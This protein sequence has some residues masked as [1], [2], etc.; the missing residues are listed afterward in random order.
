MSH[1]A[2]VLAAALHLVLDAQ[3][4]LA[5]LGGHLRLSL[6]AG[7]AVPL[8]VPTATMEH[9]PG[10][11]G[12]WWLQMPCAHP[13]APECTRMI[14]GGITGAICEQAQVPH[15]VLLHLMEGE[16]MWW[17]ESQG[18]DAA[19]ERIYRRYAKHDNWELAADEAHGF[20]AV[21][22]FLCYNCFSPYFID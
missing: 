12:L 22:D 21:T 18:H 10:L 3:K 4:E 14:V 19:G 7:P 11:D 9:I 5:D 8:R 15:G 20:V 16:L 13:E 1:S 2:T 17:Q 6:G